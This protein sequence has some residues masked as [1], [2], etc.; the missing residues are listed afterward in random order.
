MIWATRAGFGL[1]ILALLVLAFLAAYGPPPAPATVAAG[2]AATRAPAPTAPAVAQTPT[3]LAARTPTPP[4]T[5]TSQTIV[6][7][8]ARTTPTLVP[9][10]TAAPNESPAV[11]ISD[12]GFAPS[13]LRI[14]TGTTITWQNVGLQSHDVSMIG[15][16][17]A[18]WGSGLLAPNGGAS[19]TFSAPGQYDYTCSLHTMMRGRIVVEP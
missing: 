16:D 17:R 18:A 14:K 12:A 19:R 2:G 8:M 11:T 15:Q 10:A 13:E 6:S 3:P 1:A 9:R 4:A 7:R 5:A